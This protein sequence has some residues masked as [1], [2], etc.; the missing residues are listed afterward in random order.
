LLDPELYEYVRM[1]MIVFRALIELRTLLIVN[2]L[3]GVS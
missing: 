2:V 3:L 1:L